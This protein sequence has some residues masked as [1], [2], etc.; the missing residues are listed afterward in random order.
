[1]LG[2]CQTN[3]VRSSHILIMKLSLTKTTPLNTVL[4]GPDSKPL[5]E[6]HTPLDA[7]GPQETIIIKNAGDG[8]DAIKI[9]L[10]TWRTLDEAVVIVGGRSLEPHKAGIFSS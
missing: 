3:S 9:G 7:H 2:E 8:G 1:M 4:S 10:I 5:I 6:V